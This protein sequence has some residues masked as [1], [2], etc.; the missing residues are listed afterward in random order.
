MDAIKA[1]AD[2]KKLTD[3]PVREKIGRYKYIE[4]QDIKE[5]YDRISKQINDEVEALVASK[6]V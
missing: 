3:L 6:E 5:A 1:G 2:F 4:E